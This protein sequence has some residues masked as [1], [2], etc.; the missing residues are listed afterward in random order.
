M[1]AVSRGQE[2]AVE[3]SKQRTSERTR[4]Y[5]FFYC[6]WFTNELANDNIRQ[7]EFPRA[8]LSTK[9]REP[10]EFLKYWFS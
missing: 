7:R 8:L 4:Y 2:E 1:A 5:A 10:P 9:C 3:K 6:H